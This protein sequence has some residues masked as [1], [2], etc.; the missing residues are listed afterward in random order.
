MLKMLPHLLPQP[1]V[2]N[3]NVMVG[4]HGLK[5]HVVVCG[6]FVLLVTEIIYAGVYLG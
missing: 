5:S 1:N 6:S 3:A 4:S 2:E